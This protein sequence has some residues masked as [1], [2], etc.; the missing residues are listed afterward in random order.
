MPF[1]GKAKN[2]VDVVLRNVEHRIDRGDGIETFE[3]VELVARDLHRHAL[4]QLVELESLRVLEADPL[5]LLAEVGRVASP[6]P[7]QSLQ[8]GCHVTDG[9][10]ERLARILG[11]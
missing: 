3:L 4:P 6:S 11:A 1:H 9:A 5:C 10:R 2:P 8:R 7:P